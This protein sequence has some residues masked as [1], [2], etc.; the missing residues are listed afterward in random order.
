MACQ[1][2]MPVDRMPAVS[3]HSLFDWRAAMITAVCR[4]RLCPATDHSRA[5]IS[6]SP[7]GT[8]IVDITDK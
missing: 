3:W 6:D 8:A 5:D 4:H 2:I 1:W 7:S